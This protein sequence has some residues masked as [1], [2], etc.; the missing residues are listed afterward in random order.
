MPNES[1]GNYYA[2]MRRVN[3]HV[4]GFILAFII[5]N[6]KKT[7]AR[8]NAYGFCY[9]HYVQIHPYIL[10]IFLSVFTVECMRMRAWCILWK[11]GVQFF[12]QISINIHFLNNNFVGRCT[13]KNELD[14]IVHIAKRI[15]TTQKEED[16]IKM[17]VFLFLREQSQSPISLETQSTDIYRYE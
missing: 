6:I 15:M 12:L 9:S 3:M 17:V 16:G 11:K 2:F 13:K 1:T 10:T 8:M 5:D 4:C 14:Q 7:A